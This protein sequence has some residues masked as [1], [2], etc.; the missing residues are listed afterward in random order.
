MSKYSWQ[1][2]LVWP[3]LLSVGCTAGGAVVS[4]GPPNTRPSPTIQT[5]K[6]PTQS[7]RARIPASPIPSRAMTSPTQ[8]PATLGPSSRPEVNQENPGPAISRTP[9]SPHDL[10]LDL[11]DSAEEEERIAPK[12]EGRGLSAGR[13]PTPFTYDIPL[14]R[15]A[16]VDKW[17]D[18]FTGPGRS[19]FTIWLQRGGRYIERFRDI[20]RA[21]QIPEDLVYLSLIESGFSLRA[22]SRAGAVGPWQFMRATARNSGLKVGRYLDERRDPIKATIAAASLLSRL[23]TEFGD[24]Y[25]A[26]AAY[27]SGE[28]RIRRALRRT[29]RKSYW[30]L[31]HTRHIPNETKNYVPKFLAGLIIAKNPEVFG[32]S[33]IEYAKPLRYDTVSL[34]RGMSLKSIARMAGVPLKQIIDLN[35][36]LRWRITPPLKGHLL[37]L[38]TGTAERFLE[39]L[40]KS[41]TEYLPD[42]GRYRI[43][44]G[45]TFGGLARRYGVPLKILLEL[46]AHLDPRRLRV[47]MRILLPKSKKTLRV[48]LHRVKGISEGGVGRASRN[49]SRSHD[50]N[51]RNGAGKHPISHHI[52]GPGENV[53]IIARRYGVSTNQILRLNGLKMPA[54]IF[55][56]NRLRISQ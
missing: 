8:S 21:N 46:N 14:V 1:G 11:P 41:P 28:N 25:L 2:N 29:G 52:V 43:L 38:P 22:R 40:A 32:F 50:G 4:K 51:S 39:I 19:N 20:F 48:S 42:S 54:K 30:A 15:N 49:S 9:I 10:V 37:H 56:G 47:G 18:Y 53:W 23:Y 13:P 55:P 27:N 35:T 17:I 34:P 45:D 3:L 44:P 33:G 31:A 16:A 6:G 26:L 5:K 24:W 36:E 7:P 12:R